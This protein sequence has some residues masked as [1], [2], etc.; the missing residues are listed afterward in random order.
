MARCWA[1]RPCSRVGSVPP[2]GFTSCER[3]YGICKL[4]GIVKSKRCLIHRH[5][6]RWQCDGH[7]LVWHVESL[8][9]NLC[10]QGISKWISRRGIISCTRALDQQ[11]AWSCGKTSTG[12]RRL[13]SIGTKQCPENG[14][15][16]CKR[17]LHLRSAQPKRKNGALET[18][19]QRQLH[20]ARTDG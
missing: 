5:P 1:P 13:N 3:G 14:H 11:M 15:A 2:P 20:D 10:Y 17:Q 9:R 8:K 6:R 16:H 18:K 4:T 19:L 12:L 7:M